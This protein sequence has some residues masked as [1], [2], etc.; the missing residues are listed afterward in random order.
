MLVVGILYYAFAKPSRASGVTRRPSL[1][2]IRSPPLLRGG[3]VP[4]DIVRSNASAEFPAVILPLQVVTAETT[5][6]RA[7]RA[8]RVVH[9]SVVGVEYCMSVVQVAGA[10][11]L[12]IIVV[13]AAI[14]LVLVTKALRT[15]KT[16]VPALPR[17]AKVVRLVIIVPLRLVCRIGTPDAPVSAP[18][19][20]LQG[21]LVGLIAPPAQIMLITCRFGQSVTQP[22][23]V[24]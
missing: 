24:F 5:A 13:I 18:E 17:G 10:D 8:A 12:S 3:V 14:H 20:V 16:L 4:F 9:V 1:Y 19:G 22:V 11:R 2:G 15:R 23:L 6:V 21:A 7:L